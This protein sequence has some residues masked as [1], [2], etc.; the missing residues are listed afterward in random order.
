MKEE[1]E[2]EKKN[3]DNDNSSDHSDG[4][5]FQKVPIEHSIEI[6]NI[7]NNMNKIT[8]DKFKKK[9]FK[10]FLVVIV[11]IIFL[12]ITKRMIYD[13]I[14]K[15]I[16]EEKEESQENND[17]FLENS[18]YN[19]E[20]NETI[21]KEAFYLI[22]NE[23]N[24]NVDSCIQLRNPKKIK[25]IENLEIT[26][27]LEYEKFIHLKIKDAKSNRWEM[28]EKDIIN[29][30]YLNNITDSILT[31]SKN[32]KILDSEDFYVEYL[33][34]DEN[35]FEDY[36]EEKDIDDFNDNIIFDDEFSF[37]IMTDD[38]KEFY[39]FNTSQNFIF[40]DTFISFQSKLTSDKIYGFGE[41]TH[42]FELGEGIF[43]MWSFDS[44]G[45]KYD[46]GKG[47][48]NQY[49]HQPIG[50]HK[51]RFK[52]L[53][54]GFVF[55]N[56]NAQDVVLNYN[57]EDDSE[58]FLT[59][60]T[61]GGIIDYY[62][63]VDKTPEN[64]IKNIQFLLGIPPLPPYW[65]L[66]NHQ[67][68]YGI[69]SFQEFKNIYNNYK[70]YEIPIDAMWIDIDAMDNYEVFTISKKF[71][72][73]KD[74]IKEK[75]H[76]DGGKFVPIIDIGISYENKNS[77]YIQLGN[78]L[79]I[80]I[81]SNY[82]KET[83]IGKVWPG[84]TVFP[85]FF[86]PKVEKFWKK[87]LND[88]NKLVNYDGIWLDMNEPANMVKKAKC[89]GEIV[90][91]NLCT[92][93]K[94]KYYNEDLP[95]FP[96]YRKNSKNDLSFWSISE[97]ALIYGNN[98]I[99]NVK[100]LLAFYQS[101]L[102]YEFLE[103]NL[104]IRPFI[105]SRSTTLSSGKYAFHWIGDNY[106]TNENL[107]NSISAIF[108]FNIFGI[109]FTGADICGF[110]KNATK[111]LCLRWYNLGAFYPFMRNHNSK[112]AIDQYPW[113]FNN[114]NE[115]KYDSIS[116]IKKNINIRYS[117]LRYMYSQFFLISLN[118]K[119]SFFKPIMFEFPEERKSYEDIE[120]RIMFGEA[121]LICTFYDSNEE[122]K[123][124]I[125]PKS[126]FNEYPS[127][128]T[129]IYYEEENRKIKLS[130]KLNITHIFLRGGFIV[131]Y[132]NTFD[133]YIMNTIQLRDEKMNLI[134]N[135]N[136][137]K[138]SKGVIFF[139]N[140]EIN[141]IKKMKYIRVELTYRDK[142]LSINT[143]KN[144]L[145]KYNF[146]DHI[147]GTIEFWEIDEIFEIKKEKGNQFKLNIVYNKDKNKKK[148]IREGIYDKDRNKVTFE[149]SKKNDYISIFDI[150]E[151]LIH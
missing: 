32:T 111:E 48:M 95:Y 125:F 67:C 37:R 45:T 38:K 68:R 133:K 66:G 13:G 54:L 23:T 34:N 93:D 5:E 20:I 65:S 24:I 121:F 96:G 104:K 101:K 33:K 39:Y 116:N 144:N 46:D 89:L 70:K 3:D 136:N 27:N 130:G 85:D 122:D 97:N 35:D 99:Y 82:T 43:T 124:F 4:G 50:L 117:L 145:E 100:P 135:I 119:G 149:I 143:N 41:R 1:T 62:I 64:V 55:M 105:L 102:T 79:D 86:N 71:E 83:L 92:K 60:K 29:K 51:T 115:T 11:I 9:F 74:F 77:T 25:L 14:I 61:I 78:S 58:M 36:E 147:L 80:F 120:S 31:L 151:F 75:I 140:D 44:S 69:Q 112:R 26:L 72:K 94:N 129:I 6:I 137:L 59:H 134:I 146:D 123:T 114:F 103:N 19:E 16:F 113:S 128:K 142:V 126:N 139:D 12:Y 73:I 107:K 88:Y 98:T 28:P 109:P 42:D 52:N 141:T 7:I 15:Y 53:W 17:F 131:P 108:N 57:K 132:Q 49:S 90:D 110:N 2:E 76:K 81:K 47:G 63:I 150:Q 30:D 87:G 10:Q 21:N 56:T 106:S 40:S 18:T 22:Q 118:E 138:E 148:E 84:K 127:G 8:R 91:D